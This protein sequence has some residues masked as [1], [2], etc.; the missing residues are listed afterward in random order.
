MPSRRFTIVVS[1]L[2]VEELEPA[3]EEVRR[4][5]ATLPPEHVEMIEASDEANELCQAYL[6]AGIVGGAS[7]KDAAHIA[8]ATVANVDIVISWNFK[9]IVH[10][11]K[12][13]AYEGVNMLRGFRSPRIH[14]PKEVVET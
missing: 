10:F 14:S 5:L 12:I 7:S 6:D 9:H 8:A 3:P 1:D 4:V 2:T 13:S 11:E